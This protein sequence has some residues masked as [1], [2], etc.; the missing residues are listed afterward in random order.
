MYQIFT[1]DYAADGSLSNVKWGQNG[2]S[3][4]G[5]AVDDTIIA[6]LTAVSDSASDTEKLTAIEKYANLETDPFK[7]VSSG[8]SA[9]VPG[10]YYLIKDTDNSLAGQNDAYTL[11]VVKVVGNV[12]IT[13]KSGVPES[14]KK[15]KDANDSTGATTGWQDSADYDIGDEVPF[16]L[17]ATIGDRYADYKVY[18]LTFHDTQSEGLTFNKGSVN[19]YVDENA[20]MQSPTPIAASNYQVA[21][22]GLTDGCTFEIRFADLKTITGATVKAGSVIRV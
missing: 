16:Q 11:Y 15:V 18:K 3:T 1:G 4:Q 22:E 5:Q 7:T 20:G 6:E 21:T 8:N 17:T 13:P 2:T 9:Q 14:Q 19:V 12:A 10:G